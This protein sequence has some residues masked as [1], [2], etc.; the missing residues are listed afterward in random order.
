[1]F[2]DWSILYYAIKLYFFENL[3]NSYKAAT[4]SCTL[5][6]LREYR[7]T[8]SNPH[9]VVPSSSYLTVR[10]SLIENEFLIVLV[11]IYKFQTQK[12]YYFENTCLTVVQLLPR[13]NWS[14]LWIETR[15]CN[16]Q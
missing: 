3:Y 5:L 8:E 4:S 13:D 10:Q 12:K 7:Q 14:V 6:R 1:M 11:Y 9:T 2:I 16:S 15:S